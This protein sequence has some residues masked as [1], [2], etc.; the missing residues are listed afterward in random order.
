MAYEMYWSTQSGYLTNN[1]LNKSF[2]KAAQPMSKFRQFCAIK[3][4]GGKHKGDTVNWLKVSN[5]SAY[6]REV[7]ETSTIPETTLPLSWGTVTVAEYG[8]MN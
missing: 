6:G 1:E 7:S 3:E 2:Q 8:Q 4:A 5:A